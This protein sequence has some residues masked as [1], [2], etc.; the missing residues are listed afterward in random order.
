MRVVVADNEP[1]IRRG[2]V[3][4]LEEAG[5]GVAGVAG[6]TADLVCKASDHKPDVVV[7]HQMQPSNTDDGLRAAQEIREMHRDIGVV[8][9]SHDLEA[10]YALKL[11]G[12]RA[13]RVGYS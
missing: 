12:D 7:A 5:F 4:V 8:I 3:S 2:I 11:V 13:E 9:L 1:L 10:A 6:D